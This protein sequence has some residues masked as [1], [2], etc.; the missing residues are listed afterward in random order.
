MLDLGQTRLAN[1]VS[2]DAFSTAAPFPHY[3]VDDFLPTEAARSLA[4]EISRFHDF[5]KSRDYIFAKNKFEH[6]NLETI[7]P[8]CAALKTLFQSEGFAKSV[9][10]IYAKEVFLDPDF[11]GGGLHRGGTGS[12]LDM[13]ADFGIHPARGHWT[14]E[15]NILF[16][17]NEGWEPK[18]GGSLDLRHADTGERKSIAPIFNRLV[19][20]LTKSFTYHG[21]KPI[22]FPEGRFR[23]SIAAY[24]YSLR[25]DT[26]TDN[27]ART[28]TTWAPDT[29]SVTKRLIARLAPR[30][31]SLKQKI[32]GSATAKKK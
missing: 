3:V 15:L 18:W 6:P 17:L 29:G 26:S 16:Y 32:L 10:S 1:P 5:R 4:E 12:Y 8:Y 7:G 22:S 2:S 27:S 30:A 14:R 28:T 31:V 9:S 24:M 19:I 11:V 25:T 21:Y 20:M 23:T 13:H